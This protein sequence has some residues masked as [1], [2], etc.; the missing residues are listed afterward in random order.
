LKKSTFLTL[1]AGLCLLIPGYFG[2]HSGSILRPG[3]L[4]PFVF[5]E[6]FR[7]TLYSLEYYSASHWGRTASAILPVVLFFAWN[8]RLLRGQVRTPKRTLALV[9]TVVGLGLAYLV[10]SWGPGLRHQGIEYTLFVD[11]ES[12]ACIAIL[13]VLCFRSW[14][15]EPSFMWNLALHWVLFAWLAWFGFPYLGE[16][17]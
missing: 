3:P 10:A 12:V 17:I 5:Q 1:L 7:T 4:V 9:A 11:A 15:G 8:P 6:L 2:S 16:P 14:K 13:C